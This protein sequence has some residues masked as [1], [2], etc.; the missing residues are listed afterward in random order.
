MVLN[1]KWHLWH[2]PVKNLFS[3]TL[4]NFIPTVWESYVKKWLL[5]LW[6]LCDAM[7]W[8]ADTP[9]IPPVWVFKVNMPTTSPEIEA[10]LATNPYQRLK[11]SNETVICF[12]CQN[13]WTDDSLVGFKGKDFTITHNHPMAEALS[14][15]LNWVWIPHLS[16]RGVTNGVSETLCTLQN[17]RWWTKVKKPSNSNCNIPQL[18]QLQQNV[19][20]N[21]QHYLAMISN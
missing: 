18:L 9:K 15:G 16:P 2:F 4:N 3:N 10:Q 7:R 5:L 6:F 21:G 17:I 11:T 19:T 14:E 13:I 20:E 1:V 12:T 8:F